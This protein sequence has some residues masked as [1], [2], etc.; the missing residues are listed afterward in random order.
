[1]YNINGLL[2][3]FWSLSST[4]VAPRRIKS[5]STFSV[6]SSINDSLSALT[7][8]LASL[9]LSLKSFNCIT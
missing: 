7:E 5:F 4:A 1:M 8:L 3:P 2:T 9:I 6:T